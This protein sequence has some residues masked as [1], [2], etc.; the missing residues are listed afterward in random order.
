MENKKGTAITKGNQLDV[1]RR[2][3]AYEKEYREIIKNYVRSELKEGADYGKIKVKSKTTGQVFE[4]KDILFKP[5]AEKLLKIFKLRSKWVRDDEVW[6]MFGR[7]PGIVCLKCEIYDPKGKIIGEGRGVGGLHMDRDENTAVKLAEKR[8]KV[9]A[10]INSLGISDYFSQDEEIVE[11]KMV[12]SHREPELPESNQTEVR[13]EVKV[14]KPSES[15]DKI[16]FPQLKLITNFIAQGRI[17]NK[18]Y[19]EISKKEASRIIEAA[20]KV[21]PGTFKLASELQKPEEKKEGGENNG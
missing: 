3:I 12:E 18:D 2:G 19:T 9:D 5:G 15:P 6:E 13:S 10:V 1:I 17:E 21:K 7:R 16:T 14:T 8:S 11:Q 4:S 20:F